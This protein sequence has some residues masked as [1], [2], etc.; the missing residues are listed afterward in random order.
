MGMIFLDIAKAFNCFHHERLYKKFQFVSLLYRCIN[1]FK[2]HLQRTQSIRIQNQSSPAIEICSGIAKG[3]VLGP[4][5]F[6]FLF[7]RHST[8]YNALPYFTFC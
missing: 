2:S 4:L 5:F 1:W 6:I 8:Y 7:K 3:T